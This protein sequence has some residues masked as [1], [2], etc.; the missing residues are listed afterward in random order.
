MLVQEAW[1]LSI[2]LPYT[3]GSAAGTETLCPGGPVEDP[4]GSKVHV[5][6]GKSCGRTLDHWF[7]GEPQKKGREGADDVLEDIHVKYRNM[8]AQ[9]PFVWLDS[10]CGEGQQPADGRRR[11]KW[12]P[13]RFRGGEPRP[14]VVLP[15][16][17]HEWIM[18]PQRPGE[19]TSIGRWVA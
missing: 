19:K 8:D 5:D 18:Y 1:I 12:N 2:L 15:L 4:R 14:G 11:I 13:R 7:E 17:F 9:K 3:T 16:G 10:V 6:A